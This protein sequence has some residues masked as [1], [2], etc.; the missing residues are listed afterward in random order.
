MTAGSWR[1]S[2][3]C[4]VLYCLVLSHT[5]SRDSDVGFG[6]RRLAFSFCS[7]SGAA[8]R[9][10]HNKSPRQYDWQHIVIR[11]H[12]VRDSQISSFFAKQSLYLTSVLVLLTGNLFNSLSMSPGCVFLDCL[13]DISMFWKSIF[14]TRLYKN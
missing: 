8:Q 7:S 1:D 6:Q 14:V 10:F 13:L 4:R 2:T 12:S 11:G 5:M 3:S 9:E